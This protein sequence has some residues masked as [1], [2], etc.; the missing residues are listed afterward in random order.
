MAKE[1]KFKITFPRCKECVNNPICAYKDQITLL[2]SS[3]ELNLS[4]NFHPLANVVL[5]NIDIR[6]KY[7]RSDNTISRDYLDKK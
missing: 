7:Y 4:E 6:C 5:E 3:I 1:E 2:E